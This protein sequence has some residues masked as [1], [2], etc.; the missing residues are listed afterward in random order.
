[1]GEVFVTNE[2]SSTVSVI[3]DSKHEVVAT[4]TVDAGS[5]GAGP[6]GIAY[7]SSQHK[8]YVRARGK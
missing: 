4:I 1:M 8:V 7:D 6:T 3:S 5:T 2:G